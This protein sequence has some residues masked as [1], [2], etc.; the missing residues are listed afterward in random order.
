[1]TFGKIVQ[2][3]RKS[4]SLSQEEFGELFN[5]TRQSVSKWETDAA[6]PELDTLIKIADYSNLSIDY[7]LGREQKNSD[8]IKTNLKKVQQI[9]MK[10]RL[11]ILIAVIGLVILT[12]TLS[13]DY[14]ALGFWGNPIRMLIEGSFISTRIW[15]LTLISLIISG[16]II[17]WMAIHSN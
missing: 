10:F 9:K 11:G 16:I 6:M 14:I 4:S 15:Y 17:C 13:V 2:D 3:I 12:V 8:E 7:L 1:M 5:V